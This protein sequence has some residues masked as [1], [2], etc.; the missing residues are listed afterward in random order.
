MID[1]YTPGFISRMSI[2]SAH[3]KYLEAL[4]CLSLGLDRLVGAKVDSCAAHGSPCT[5]CKTWCLPQSHCRRSGQISIHYRRPEARK[6]ASA[7]E[8]R[9]QAGQPSAKDC[10]CRLAWDMKILGT[11]LLQGCTAQHQEGT[12][13]IKTMV[14]FSKL[15]LIIEQAQQLQTVLDGTFCLGIIE[16]WADNCRKA[17]TSLNVLIPVHNVQLSDSMQESANAR[18]S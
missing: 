5:I 12:A 15:A 6:A 16:F 1:S 9:K 8:C 7:F 14:L 4:H 3:I 17:E 11:C 10:S 18:Q 2:L 13:S